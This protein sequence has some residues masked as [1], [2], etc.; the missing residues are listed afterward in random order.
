MVDTNCD[1]EPIDRVIPSNDDAIRA[2]K[3]IAGAIAEAAEEGSAMRQAAYVEE[4]QQALE[5]VDVTRRVY[6]PDDEADY[7]GSRYDEDDDEY[8]EYDFDDDDEDDE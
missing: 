3:L 2:I 7:Y 4:E 8:A 1:P 6:S 5:G